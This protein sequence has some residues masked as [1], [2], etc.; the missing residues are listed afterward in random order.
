MGETTVTYTAT[1][2]N[3]NAV[4]LVQI[5][6]VYTDAS[7]SIICPPD[8]TL[9]YNPQ[10]GDFSEDM[11]L[12]QTSANGGFVLQSLTSVL[13]PATGGPCEFQRTRTYTATWKKKD[14]TTSKSCDRTYYYTEDYQAPDITCALGVSTTVTGMTSVI[15]SPDNPV[16]T[17]N[18]S[19]SNDIQFTFS[20]SDGATAIS[21]PYP[22]GQTTIT[23]YATD[24]AG[25]VGECTQDI[26]VISTS[27][28]GGVSAGLALWFKSNEGVYNGQ[29]PSVDGG[30]VTL[31]DDYVRNYDAKQDVAADQPTFSVTTDDLNNYNPGLLFN[32]TDDYMLSDLPTEGLESTNSVFV[33]VTPATGGA[34]VGLG[35]GSYV[36]IDNNQ[37]V[38]VVNGT[39]TTRSAADT[40]AQ[41]ATHILSAVKSGDAGGNVSIF[42]DGVEMIYSSTQTA[43]IT[44]AANTR[45]GVDNAGT[46]AAWFD[47]N[48]AEVILYSRN[49]SAV[50]RAKVESYLA[51][52]YGITLGE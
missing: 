1:D 32:G 16:A 34:V 51:V 22:L 26:T 10:E 20:R 3:G 28:P 43:A 17:D 21:D 6:E 36:G 46:G 18:C 47:G 7:F 40:W 35:T 41:G 31:W 14:V 13:N 9:G 38:Y 29:L 33:V 30:V 27:S 44:P 12:V 11:G 23:W 42:L 15:L 37:A 48:I 19:A 25:N 39:A 5:V 4:T 52:K 50:E 8:A 2:S 45:I 49:L 24:L